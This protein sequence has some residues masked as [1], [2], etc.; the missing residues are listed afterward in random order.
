[1]NHLLYM[2]DLKL[3]SNNDKQLEGL[4]NT[5]KI[6]S[7]DIEVQFELDM[8]A[9]APFK[10]GK[11]TKITNVKLDDTCVIQ[12]LAQEGTYKYLGINEGNGIKHAATKEK[13]RKEYYR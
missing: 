4:L 5:V 8:C 9:K 3:Y 11:L 12:E 10:K 2:D 7:D 6:F 13:V 1:M